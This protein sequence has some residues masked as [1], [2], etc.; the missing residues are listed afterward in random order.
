MKI[1]LPRSMYY[2]YRGWFLKDFFER[3]GCEVVLS[4]ETNR[5]IIEKGM[6]L[7]N[8]EMCL[9][10]KIFLG[11]VSS[12]E[13]KCDYVVV[14]RIDNYGISDQTCTNFLALPDL[15]RNYFSMDLLEYS[16]NTEKKQT[17]LKGLLALGKKL[18]F[19]KYEVMDAYYLAKGKEKDLLEQEYQKSMRQLK[20]P[21]K[22][23]LL[24]GHPYNLYDSFIGKEIVSMLKKM[25]V[26]VLYSDK[27][28]RKLTNQY[29]KLYSK[30][31]YFKY[32]K[33]AIGSIKLLESK[34]DGVIFLSTFPCGPDSLVNE[35]IM[36]KLDLPTLN[37]IVDDLDALAGM[38]T[39][40]ES[41]FDII[42]EK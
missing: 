21:L 18:G 23:I 2:Y 37:L 36:R 17:E 20:S 39:R 15:L 5:A 12:L 24:V 34:I 35:L 1:G 40:L 22:K 29:S 14:P 32:N 4:K 19:D 8:D 10:L 7:A 28:N 42:H 30:C 3:L 41:F 16:I 33:E 38:E 27:W 31:L 6:E 9:S 13:G 25:K 26:E 11:H